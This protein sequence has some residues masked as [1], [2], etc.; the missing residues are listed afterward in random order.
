MLF[1]HFRRKKFVVF[2]RIKHLKAFSSVTKQLNICFS[3]WYMLV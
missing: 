2:L 3:R 1:I